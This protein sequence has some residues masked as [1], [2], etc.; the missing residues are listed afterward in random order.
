VTN[1]P[2]EVGL[3]LQTNKRPGEYAA[4]ALIAERG[5]FDVVTTFNDLWYQPALP[6]LLEIAAATERVRVGPSCLNPF[7]LHPVELAG[8]TAALDLV[9]SG[10]AFLG[11]AA[12]AW[13]ADLG[14]DQRRPVETIAEAWEIVTRLLAGD[15]SGF[16]GE[17]FRLA[18]GVGLAYPRERERVPLLIGSWSPRLTS[19]AAGHAA[20]LKI[21]GSANPAMVQ[22]ARERLGAADVGIVAGAVTVVDTDDT[23]AREHAR[24]QVAMYLEVVAGL[25]P[26]AGVPAALIAA[27]AE[28]LSA[29]DVAGA[30]SLISDEVLDLFAF[31][32]TPDRIASQALALYDAGAR[33]VE[34]GTPHG[35]D[36]SAGVEL[37]AAEVLP[38]LGL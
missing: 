36:E 2:R 3:G 38:R 25:D 10:R 16:E 6:A 21:G 35:L 19:F 12:G 20:E 37:L 24:H 9:S 1:E 14:L 11:L 33:R 29:G 15:R 23:R 30:A 17:V 4:L 22:L 5:G 34:F 8:Q 31:S 27:I 32:G 7:S 18:P 13:L 26:V 28:Q